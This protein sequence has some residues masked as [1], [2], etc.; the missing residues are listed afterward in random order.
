MEQMDLVKL[1]QDFA[2]EDSARNYLERIR[3]PNGPVCPHC[4]WATLILVRVVPPLRLKPAPV[5][6]TS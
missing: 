1:A 6:D 2:D 4:G 5:A 3:W